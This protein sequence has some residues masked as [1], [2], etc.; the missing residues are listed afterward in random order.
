[1]D[2]IARENK[3]PHGNG[4]MAVLR[5]DELDGVTGGVGKTI[6]AKSQN[7]RRSV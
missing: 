4:D 3:S 5:D 6:G 7:Y 1:M 2:I